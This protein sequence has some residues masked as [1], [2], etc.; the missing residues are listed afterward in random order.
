MPSELIDALKLAAGKETR[1]ID[2]RDYVLE[3]PIRECRFG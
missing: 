2:G 1:R 3:F